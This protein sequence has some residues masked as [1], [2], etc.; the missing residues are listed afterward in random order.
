MKLRFEKSQ[1]VYIRVSKT[2]KKISLSFLSP[3]PPIYV[4]LPPSLYLSLSIFPLSSLFRHHSRQFQWPPLPAKP[5]RRSLD[6]GDHEPRLETQ[7]T[8]LIR[9]GFRANP[10]VAQLRPQHPSLVLTIFP[11]SR[12]LIDPRRACLVRQTRR[13][14]VRHDL[15]AP[16]SATASH[17]PSHGKSR[18]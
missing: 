13:A 12:T 9:H 8:A 10:R 17:D 11:L 6:V 14:S 18:P 4:F 16:S 7:R 3:F 15:G 5:P 1:R 2:R